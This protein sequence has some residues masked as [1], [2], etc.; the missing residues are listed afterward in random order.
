MR[1]KRGV[2]SKCR[3]SIVISVLDEPED[4]NLAIEKVLCQ[5]SDEDFEIIAVDGDPNGETI[6]AIFHMDVITAVSEKGRAKQMNAGAD[7]AKGEIL[8]FLHADTELPPLALEKIS[9]TLEDDRYVGGAFDLGIDSDN[10][11]IK[12]IA[13]RARIRSRLTRIPYGDQAIFVRKRYFEE[14][15]GFK[16][17]PFL[18]DVELMRRIKKRGDKIF[19]LRDQVKTSARRWEKEGIL[20]T[21]LRN[22][23]VVSLYRLGVSPHRLARYYRSHSDKTSTW[24]F[25][26]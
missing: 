14:I 11:W 5:Q 23:L 2:S 21:T 19:I 15:G 1:H 10:F 25:P 8:L 7:L 24:G 16:D 6:N 17:L 26:L 12:V 18:E 9:R 13:A 4:I 22:M 20:Y 3:I